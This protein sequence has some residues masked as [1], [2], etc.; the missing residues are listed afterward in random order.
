MLMFDYFNENLAMFRSV[1]MVLSVM[2]R[3]NLLAKIDQVI[4]SNI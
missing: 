4:G 1:Q 3:E 2:G